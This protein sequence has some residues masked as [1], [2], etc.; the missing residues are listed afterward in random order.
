M[1][2]R[3]S[4]LRFRVIPCQQFFV[5]LKLTAFKDNLSILYTVV[6]KFAVFKDKCRDCSSAVFGLPVSKDRLL[7]IMY[8]PRYLRRKLGVVFQDFWRK[9]RPAVRDRLRKLCPRAC[10][11]A[12][13]FSDACLEVCQRDA[14]TKY[15]PTGFWRIAVGQ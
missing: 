5:V 2:G 8:A 10:S 12:S 7:A 9:R 4:S 14:Y 3:S 1:S 6:L 13:C 15:R 11:P